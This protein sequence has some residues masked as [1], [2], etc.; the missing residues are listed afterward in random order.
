MTTSSKTLDRGSQKTSRSHEAD[1][2]GWVED[3]MA[4]LRANDVGSIDAP[5]LTQELAEL[6]RSEFQRLVSAVRL[7][8]H[9]LLKWDYQQSHRSRSWVL[10]IEGHRA[11]IEDLLAENPSLKPRTNEA[12]L[13]AYAKARRDAMR[14]T[15]LA[16]PVLPIRCPYDWSEMTT[17]VIEWDDYRT[18]KG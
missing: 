5:H 15:G 18:P 2:Y 6:G 4:L 11:D 14:E 7:V 16:E 3:Q 13:K 17:R 1:L 9:H 12:L 8:L 10:S